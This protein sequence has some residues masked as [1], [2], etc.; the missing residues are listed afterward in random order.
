M[1]R[2]NRRQMLKGSVL[3]A[4]ALALAGCGQNNQNQN[5]NQNGDNAPLEQARQEGRVTVYTVL[6][7]P[8]MSSIFNP[9]FKEDYPWAD[10]NVVALGPSE[11]AS[12]MSSEF[13]ADQV[14]ADVAINTQGTMAPLTGN[15]VFREAAEDGPV[16]EQIG[17][18]NYDESKYTSTWFPCDTIPQVMVVNTDKVSLDNA[19]KSWNALG[20]DRWEGELAFDRPSSLNVSGSVFATLYGTM[21]ESEWRTLMENIAANNPTLTESASDTFRVLAQG[22]ASVG[23]GLL[24]NVLSAQ[25]EGTTPVRVQWVK[26]TTFLNVPIYMANNAR[27]PAMAQLY[28]KW[29]V[30]VSGQEAMAESNR[31]PPHNG[32]A[33]YTFEAIPSDVDLRPQAFNTP[34]FFSSPDE[35][36][37]RFQE[38]FG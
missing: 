2:V 23:I 24:N 6:D 28:T 1:T 31:V 17:L 20:R 30:S 16:M 4:G 3:T 10:V 21:E 15:N 38:I 18:M 9:A 11:I 22:E 34:S 7:Q 37:N 32:V 19:P 14:Q 12:R 33:S 13:Q 5:G 36:V 26:P 27:N 8:D 29:F 25:Q 35:W